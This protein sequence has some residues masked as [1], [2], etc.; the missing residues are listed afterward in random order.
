MCLFPLEPDLCSP[1]GR[2]QQC[3]ATAA[4]TFGFAMSPLFASR[5]AERSRASS[6]VTEFQKLQYAFQ[7]ARNIRHGEAC[8]AHAMAS[9]F[10]SGEAVAQFGHG[11][12]C[13][14]HRLF[15][16]NEESAWFRT[17][18]FL[19]TFGLGNQ[20]ACFRRSRGTGTGGRVQ[21]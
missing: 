18:L 14:R 4:E 21:T 10:S 2:L 13:L 17:E 20:S 12:G 9:C 11:T 8:H 6:T 7:S 5:Q 3:P 15:R 16:R 1:A 19:P